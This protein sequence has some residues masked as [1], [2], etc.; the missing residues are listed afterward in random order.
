MK[1]PR[2][3]S[4]MQPTGPIHLG[5]LEGALR[6]WVRLQNE[7]NY[8]MFCF[9]ANWHS[10]TTQFKDPAVIEKYSRMLVVD[11][12]SVGLDPEK[13]AIFL[14]SDVKQHA[15]LHL[16]LSMITP[17]GWLERQPTYKDKIATLAEKYNEENV[18]EYISYGLLGYPVLQA[19]DILIYKAEVVPVGRDQA[20][21]LE[22]AREIARRFNHLY[23]EIF[24][25]PQAL[26][27]EATGTL[28]GIDRRKMSSSYGNAIFIRDTPEEV[29]EKVNQMV[30]T[31]TKI[32]KTDPGVPEN[33]VVC[34][35]R[36]I[37]DPEGYLVS[38]EEDRQ[39]KRGCT[40]NK[41]ELAEILNAMLDPIR[42]KREELERN[43]DYV[44]EVLRKGAERAAAVAEETMRE[45]RAAMKLRP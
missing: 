38:W 42:R 32:R 4:G 10:Y 34:Q 24:P 12:I 41:K 40:Q 20:P 3:L 44:D 1:R 33:C 9:V 22:I 11:Y 6:Q 26:I 37:Y 25:E 29:V 8:D 39:G 14:Q 7:G 23:G 13:T 45:V 16:L 15:E 28:P 27:S 19:A 21:H 36:K 35:L 18:A 31:E 30:T 2:L 5:R 43:P 17:V